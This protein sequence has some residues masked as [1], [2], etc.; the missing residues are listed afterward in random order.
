MTAL[1]ITSTGT[2]IGKTFVMAGLIRHLRR[3][4][5]P[6]EAIKPIV[7]GFDPAQAVVSDPGVLLAELGRTATPEEIERISPWRFDA[8]LSP[9]LAA[10]REGRA[11][12]FDALVEFSRQALA[13]HKGTLLI[14]GVGGVMVPLDGRRTVLDWMT[15]LRVPVL[16]VAGSYLGAISHTLTALHVLAQRKLDIAATVVSESVGSPVTLDDTVAIIER[17]SSGIEVIGIPR[18]AAGADHM[19]FGRIGRLL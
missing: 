15:V 10:A 11:L 12:D 5:R 2:D 14:E 13:A 1:F 7:S 18:L 19:A 4:G 8:A 9:D 17:F 3:A 16:L 6:V